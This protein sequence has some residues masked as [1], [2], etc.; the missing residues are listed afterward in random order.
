MHGSSGNA[1][2]AKALAAILMPTAVVGGRIAA[3]ASAFVSTV[4]AT[5]VNVNSFVPVRNLLDRLEAMGRRAEP[6]ATAGTTNLDIEAVRIEDCSFQLPNGTWLFRS[7]NVTIK[8]GHPIVVRGA[9]GTGKSTFASLV[10][11]S[12]DPSS[13]RVV[14]VLKDGK[15]MPPHE[16]SINYLSQ[17]PALL[18]GTVRSNRQAPRRSCL[19]TGWYRRWSRLA[20]G[21]NSCRKEASTRRYSRAPAT[22]QA[23]RS[24][25][26]AWPGC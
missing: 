6:S 21:T 4:Y 12:N 25:E 8:P 7:L 18:V 26:W 22:F 11:G 5:S 16:D 23:V 19:T 2:T 1:T 24:A 17:E 10:A 15:E 20:C 3:A 14:Y 13:G 9:S